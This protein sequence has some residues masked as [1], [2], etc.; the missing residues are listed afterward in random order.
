MLACTIRYHIDLTKKGRFE[1]YRFQIAS[2]I[3]DYGKFDRAQAPAE[4]QREHVA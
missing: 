4:C 2:A 1:E 3:R